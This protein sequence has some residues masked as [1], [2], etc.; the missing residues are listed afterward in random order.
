MTDGNASREHNHGI[1]KRLVDGV[2][3]VLDS[4]L[5]SPAINHWPAA[6]FI[7]AAVLGCVVWIPGLREWIAAHEATF[8]ALLSAIVTGGIFGS[9]M[10]S[11]TFRQVLREEVTALFLGDPEL[12]KRR[13]DREELWRTVTIGM[14]LPP[15]IAERASDN[16]FKTI[17]DQEKPFRYGH[18]TRTHRLSWVNTA[19][20]DVLAVQTEIKSELIPEGAPVVF[21]KTARIR[22]K[23]G[24]PEEF[25]ADTVFS[26]FFRLP[27]T[28]GDAAETSSEREVTQEG[29]DVVVLL[30]ASLRGDTRYDVREAW[31]YKQ[32]L[33][34]DNAVQFQSQAFVDSMDVNVAYDPEQMRVQFRVIGKAGYRQPPQIGGDEYPL[35]RQCPSLISPWTGYMLTVSRILKETQE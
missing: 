33:D 25:T 20:Q 21:K 6:L 15:Q 4:Y 29:E 8:S 23:L 18:V 34:E 26:H 3:D 35:R 17:W 12:V 27:R 24:A 7:A 11:R 14:G 31:S 32:F 2:G 1:G 19:R 22:T 9:L 28:L 13:S 16:L 10:K 30:K 5:I